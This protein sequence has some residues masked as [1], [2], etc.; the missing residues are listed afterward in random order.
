M[1]LYQTTVVGL[2]TANWRWTVTGNA[3][4]EENVDVTYQEW[5]SS[6]KTWITQQKLDGVP[7]KVLKLLGEHAENIASIAEVEFE[8]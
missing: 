5:D 6:T 8:I 1:T 4:F 7:A 2:G 3:D